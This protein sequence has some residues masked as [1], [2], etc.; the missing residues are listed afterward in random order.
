MVFQA[1]FA[2]F[3]IP[4]D[5]PNGWLWSDPNNFFTMT[6]DELEV[7]RGEFFRVIRNLSLVKAYNALE[8]LLFQ[9][10][11]L[12]YFPEQFKT[13]G[14]TMT[15]RGDELIKKA[16]RDNPAM[17]YLETRNNRHL[18]GFLCHHSPSIATFVT[19]PVRIDHQT[20]WANFFEFA[21]ILRHVNTHHG[22]LL[23]RDSLNGLQS[24]AKDVFQ[25]SFTCTQ[26]DDSLY[27]LHPLEGDQFNYLITLIK[28]LAANT[29][30]FM[31]D[32]PDLSFLDL[33]KC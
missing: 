4:A 21:S 1:M 29:V 20:T 10:V 2:V 31:F 32:E 14:K 9:A 25:R 26:D 17:G 5:R 30:K 13:T 33:H 24:A 22:G 6:A 16:Y 19:Q 28:D 18:I 15:K 12:R 11:V 23:T 3:D 27:I 8:M 7:H